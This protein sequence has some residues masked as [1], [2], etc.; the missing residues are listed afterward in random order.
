MKEIWKS[1]KG[2]E[3]HYEVSNLGNV[4]SL[5]RIV[6]HGKGD[7][8]RRLKGKLLNKSLNVGY[9]AVGLRIDGNYKLVKVHR[10]VAGAFIDNPENKPCVN[11]KDR[12]R[13]NNKVD[14]LEWCTYKEN[15]QHAFNLGVNSAK[16]EDHGLSLLTNKQVMEI[17]KKLSNGEKGV[18]L[19]REFGVSPTIISYIKN[20]K[21]YKNV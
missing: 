7:S 18:T 2:F 20:R 14:N 21:T 10:L 12:D 13:L 15:S 19:A 1:I 17:R 3:G 4:R 5:D 11:H 6:K 8:V 9:Y 16:C